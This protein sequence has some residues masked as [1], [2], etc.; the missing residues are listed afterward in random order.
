MY[1]VLYVY[2]LIE[3]SNIILYTTISWAIIWNP[4]ISEFLVC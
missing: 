4:Q 2:Y 3:F 1:L